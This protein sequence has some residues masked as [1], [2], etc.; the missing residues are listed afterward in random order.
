MIFFKNFTRQSLAQQVTIL[1][2][3]QSQKQQEAIPELFELFKRLTDEIILNMI[4]STL[5]VLL[6]ENETETI[7]G[8]SSNDP[9][10]K[11]LCIEIAGQQQFRSA[12]P[13]L[14]QMVD[15]EKNDIFLTEVIVALSRLG[16]RKALIQIIDKAET[17][18]L[19]KK[20]DSVIISALEALAQIN[21]DEALSFLVSKIHHQ[22]PTIRRL[23]QEQ[24]IK[25]GP[26]VI[27]FL[28]THFSQEDGDNKIMVANVLSNL[29]CE[30]GIDILVTGLQEGT[31]NH[32]NIRHTI[33]E[34]LGKMPSVKNRICLLNG[35]GEKDN[36]TLIAVV[37]SLDKQLDKKTGDALKKLLTTATSQSKRL[38]YAVVSSRALNIFEALYQEEQLAEHIID[39]IGR[40]SDPDL[41]A[42]FC[43]KLKQIG[44]TRAKDDFERLTGFSEEISKGQRQILVVDDSESMLFFFRSVLSAKGTT[45]ETAENGKKALDLLE[46]GKAYDLIFADINM[47]IMDGIE[48][49]REIRSNPTL[50]RT[51]VVIVTAESDDSQ[52]ALSKQAGADGILKKPLSVAELKEKAKEFV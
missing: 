11:R 33:Y 8:L 42:T 46:A 49:T 41:I 16:A 12:I 39:I 1:Q 9:A 36:S 21:D 27:P 5:L 51:P 44:T 7:K 19:Y 2:G 29:G 22:H 35:L 26:R 45:I 24:L 28:A 34:T 48:L 23:I 25:I 3:I 30:E 47:P 43:K 14:E 50:E 31:L 17:D 4:Y 37:S 18:I 32:T 15:T 40:S 10:T 13:V 38:I 52:I 6:L 20:C